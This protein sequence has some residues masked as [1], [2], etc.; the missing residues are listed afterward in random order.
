MH[1]MSLML[2][3]GIAVAIAGAAFVLAGCSSNRCFCNTHN[4][5]PAS[6]SAPLN[7][8]PQEA[9]TR[10]HAQAKITVEG[11]ETKPYDQTVN[12]ALVEIHLKEIFTGEIEGE[13]TVRALQLLLV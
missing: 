10:T 8:Q 3:L 5:A 9:R 6:V 7:S 12:P 2:P 1:I 13:S 11:S 4:S